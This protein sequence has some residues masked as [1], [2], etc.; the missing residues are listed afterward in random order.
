MWVLCLRQL[1]GSCKGL[2]NDFELLGFDSRGILLQCRHLLDQPL[3]D[4]LCEELPNAQRS[5]IGHAD[6]GAKPAL[7]KLSPGKNI[8]RPQKAQSEPAR[9][10]HRQ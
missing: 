9:C 3:V 8:E 10:T 6:A 1:L 2:L 4:Q 5:G 7:K